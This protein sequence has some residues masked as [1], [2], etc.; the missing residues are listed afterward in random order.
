M[1]Q[2]YICAY[3]RTP[4]GRFG[5]ALSKVRPDDLGAIALK[6]LMETSPSVDWAAV[7][8]VIFGNANQAFACRH[9]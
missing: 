1:T 2:A 7:D 3:I 9:A 6:A 8:D 4:I 5:G